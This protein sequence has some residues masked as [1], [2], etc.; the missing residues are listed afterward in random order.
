MGL[1]AMLAQL[2]SDGFA[3]PIAYVSRALSP[4]ERNY[5]ITDLE[6]LA[7]VWALSHFHYYL[8]GHKVTVITDHTAVKAILDAPNPSGRHA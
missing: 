7:V 8:D 1:G 4:S 5:G 6:T 2:Q 3:H